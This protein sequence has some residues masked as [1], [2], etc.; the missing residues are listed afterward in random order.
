[1]VTV[2]DR[3]ARCFEARFSARVPNPKVGRA[4]LPERS[5]IR[6]LVGLIT[7]VE[8]ARAKEQMRAVD[9]QLWI[10]FK[11][12]IPEYQAQLIVVVWWLKTQ[13]TPGGSRG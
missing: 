3:K 5:P 4:G 1:M 6:C 10:H 9:G 13:V 8:C 2:D 12:G 7:V 11:S